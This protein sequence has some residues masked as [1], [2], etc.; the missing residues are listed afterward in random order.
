MLNGKRKL[1]RRTDQS[2][3]TIGMIDS[4]EK[5]ILEEVM[6]HLRRA[7][8]KLKFRIDPQDDDALEIID[9]AGIALS[10]FFEIL[11]FILEPYNYSSPN[12]A[13]CYKCF[14]GNDSLF[15][16]LVGA[17]EYLNRSATSY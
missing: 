9:I 2:K 11:K 6:L 15:A 10:T 14:T 12:A 7:D 8:E 13:L 4:P 3:Q 16:F 17:F 1:R 5:L